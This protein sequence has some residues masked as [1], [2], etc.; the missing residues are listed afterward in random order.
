MTDRRGRPITEDERHIIADRKR[1]GWTSADIAK[2]IGVAVSAVN[3]ALVNVGI[4]RPPSYDWHRTG[5][6]Q[7]LRWM[8]DAVCGTVVG[9]TELPVATQKAICDACPVV[10]PCRRYG[11]TLPN[12]HGVSRDEGP[13]FGGLTPRELAEM[14]EDEEENAA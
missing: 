9:F 10:D 3:R 12:A 13:V 2:D 6:R 11:A 1:A 14:A 8:A 5:P 4:A 7:D